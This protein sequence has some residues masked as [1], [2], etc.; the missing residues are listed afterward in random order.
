[1]VRWKCLHF[2]PRRCTSHSYARPLF[3]SRSLAQSSTISVYSFLRSIHF[4]IIHTLHSLC[5]VH[6]NNKTLNDRKRRRERE[7]AHQI[8]GPSKRGLEGGGSREQ[9]TK[10]KEP[11]NN[12]RRRHHKYN[13]SFRIPPISVAAFASHTRC[14]GSFLFFFIQFFSRSPFALRFSVCVLFAIFFLSLLHSFIVL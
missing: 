1:M 5:I 14:S 13:L 2:I 3:S 7:R 10:K 11:E 6:T 8:R 4:I 12:Y 9:K